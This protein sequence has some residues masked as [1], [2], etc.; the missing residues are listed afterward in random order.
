M[1]N[2]LLFKHTKLVLLLAFVLFSGWGWGQTAL[3]SENFSSASAG[4]NTTSGGSSTTWLGSTNFP[5][6]GNS[7]AYNAGG[8]VKIGASSGS[9]Y[10]L[11][12]TLDLSTDGGA[13][14]IKF[15]VRWEPC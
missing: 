13:F 10:I 3:L 5:S 1:K 6:T 4:D 11:S 15:D 14:T 7:A 9:G 12:K 8:A 2:T